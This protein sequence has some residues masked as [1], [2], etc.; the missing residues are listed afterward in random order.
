MDEIFSSLPPQLNTQYIR[1]LHRLILGAVSLDGGMYK[2]ENSFIQ[3][4]D[5]NGRYSVRFVPVSAEE[6][7]DAM[8][9]MIQAYHSARQ[10]SEISSLLLDACFI[11]DFLCIH[12]F[13]DGNGRVSR[14]LTN[15]LL[16]RNNF[17]VGRYI[18]IEKKIEQYMY[19]YYKALR[20][21]SAGWHENRNDYTHFIVFTL[22]ILYQ[23][24]KDLD[25]RFL[26]NQTGRVP[27]SRRVENSVMHSA[28]PVSKSDLAALHPDISVTQLNGYW[29]NC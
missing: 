29:T 27:K 11:V 14:L 5:S 2:T 21:S 6:T 10:D 9:Q 1:H 17:T 18:S 19:N 12:P 24:F 4:I 22:Q 8:E 15:L 20:L 25:S 13:R 16:L 23:A 26:E 3:E 28:L 7:E